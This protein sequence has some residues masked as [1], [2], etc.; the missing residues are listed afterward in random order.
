MKSACSAP[1]ASP[2][3]PRRG[4]GGRS[5]RSRATSPNPSLVRRGM[6]L[7]WIKPADRI[8]NARRFLFSLDLHGNTDGGLHAALHIFGGNQ[9]ATAADARADAHRSREAHLVGAIV[10]AH[11]DAAHL[12]D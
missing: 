9:L 5:N 2:S 6:L 7:D 1:S 11:A 4:P 10:D 8:D 12:D 3:L